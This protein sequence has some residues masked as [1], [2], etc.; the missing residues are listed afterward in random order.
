MAEAQSVT[1]RDKL[2]AGSWR[3]V[4][5]ATE[6][7]DM[8]GGRRVVVHE[9]PQRDEPFAEDMG[10]AV[11]RWSIDCLIVGPD[12]MTGRDALIAALEAP[13]AGTLVHPYVGQQTCL[14]EQ[15]SLSESSDQGG[16]ARFSLSFTEAGRL[17][18]AD[19]TADSNAA[20]S[21]TAA[22]VTN[23][24]PAVFTDRFS[25]ASL[26][27]FVEDGAAGLVHEFVGS[28]RFIGGMLG[29]AGKLLRT[30]QQGLDMANGAIALVRQ[31]VVLALSVK[32]MIGALGQL[33]QLPLVRLRGLVRM[34][35][36]ATRFRDVLGSTPARQAERAN[37]VAFVELVQSLAAAELVRTSA[38]MG[39]ASYG[40]ATR[41]RDWLA[42]Q[43]DALALTA[44]NAGEDASGA[45]YDQ[46]RL[47]MIRDVTDRGASLARLRSVTPLVTEPALVI[48]N[49]L[50]GPAGIE[51]TA[52]DIV[53]RNAIRHPGFVPGRVAIDV[54]TAAEAARG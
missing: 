44:Y 3:G 23:A 54:L 26:P 35:D 50:F 37:R 29:G 14:A 27:G 42:D 45:R 8:T 30:Y 9:F 43:I 19:Q 47:A 12:Y 21:A 34:I 25:V 4:P 5:F 22:A 11:R 13:G 16:M 49:R 53:N 41:V 51:A 28:S 38:T 18:A 33:G 7:H 2:L 20:A 40:E 17:L 39:F 31:P 36:D 10:R 15:Y 52:A 24:A 48:A 1:W 32:S 46:L 6:R